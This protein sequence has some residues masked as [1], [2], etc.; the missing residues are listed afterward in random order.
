[1]LE[2]K[3]MLLPKYSECF[4]TNFFCV[5]NF[6]ICMYESIFFNSLDEHDLLPNESHFGIMKYCRVQFHIEAGQYHTP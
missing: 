1:M 6:Q 5:D 4:Q 2:K 3:R